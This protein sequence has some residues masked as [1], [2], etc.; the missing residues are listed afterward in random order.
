[1]EITAEK[2]F[3]HFRAVTAVSVSRKVTNTAPM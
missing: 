3:W 1:L 2:R